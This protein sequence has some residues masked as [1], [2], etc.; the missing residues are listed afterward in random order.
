MTRPDQPRLYSDLAEWFHLLTAPAE[1]ADEAAFYLGQI[2]AALGS[3]PGSLLELGSGG[4]NM[5]LHYKQ[6]VEQVTLSDLSPQMLAVSQRINPELEHI[7]GDMRILRLDRSFDAVLVHDA[8]GY[9]TTEADLLETMRT[10]FFHCRPGGVTIF[11]P[12][13]I[14][15]TFAEGTESGGHSE[16][17]RALRYLMW[18]WDPNPA[19]DCYVVDFAYLLREDGQPMRVIHDRHTEGLF[20]R[21]TWL[22]LLGEAGFQNIR[23][24]PLEHPDVE[25][26]AVEV[27]I[28]TRHLLE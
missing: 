17:G 7:A 13:A 12:D 3:P 24:K 22:R 1:Y 14:R 8:V 9:L 4:G 19:D 28:A 21:E 10:A 6:R 20:S 5:A 15:E 16:P 23:V 18:T 26:G 11:A 2:D 25:P 27:F